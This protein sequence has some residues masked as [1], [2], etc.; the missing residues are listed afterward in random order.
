MGKKGRL[1][2]RPGTQVSLAV[3]TREP[4]RGNNVYNLRPL[5]YV[6]H[7]QKKKYREMPLKLA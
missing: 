4:E 1:R 7:T 2:I 3:A 5:C 6:D